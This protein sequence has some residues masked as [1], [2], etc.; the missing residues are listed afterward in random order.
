MPLVPC[1]G[2][3]AVLVLTIPVKVD[4]LVVGEVLNLAVVDHLDFR[5]MV[6]CLRIG[7]WFVVVGFVIDG[8]ELL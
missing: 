6:L 8:V 4:G 1:F 5:F 3:N 2:T 7:K